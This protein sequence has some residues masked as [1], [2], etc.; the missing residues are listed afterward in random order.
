[1]DE[2]EL[3]TLMSPLFLIPARNEEA[4]IGSVLS[5]CRQF[6]PTS[7]IIVINN[8]SEDN[9]ESVANEYGA[10][11]VFEANPGYA[12]ALEC[13]YR[14]AL[15]YHFSAL[16]QLDADGQHPFWHVP[17]LLETLST[18]EADW[19][20]GSRHGTGSPGGVLRRF[21]SYCMGSIARRKG[22]D[23]NDLSSGFWVM[24]RHAVVQI[25]SLLDDQCVDAN[26]RLMAKRSGLQIVET[27]TPMSDRHDGK[28]MHHGWK[29][30]SHG[31]LS[32]WKLLRC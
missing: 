16:V 5:G 27:P 25:L 20:I 19:V 21:G 18:C 2:S 29:T 3:N 26:L 7:Q 1:M 30:L 23:L 9:T 15:Q 22:I 11:V 10:K 12:K 4:S 28:S 13:G 24:R 14:H 17:R 31:L 32:A 8:G 6:Y